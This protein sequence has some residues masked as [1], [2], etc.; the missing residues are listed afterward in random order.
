MSG[1]SSG[2][3]E[4]LNRLLYRADELRALLERAEGGQIGALARELSELD[5]VVEQVAALRAARQAR[6][7]AEAMMADPEMRELA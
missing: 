5:P 1:T 7:E 6:D 4:K 2:L 3:D